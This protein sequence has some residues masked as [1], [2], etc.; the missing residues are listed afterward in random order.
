MHRVAAG[1]VVTEN[2]ICPQLSFITLP[3][4]IPAIQEIIDQGTCHAALVSGELRVGNLHGVILQVIAAFVCPGASE[5]IHASAI[6]H[7]AGNMLLQTIVCAQNPAEQHI[8]LW[9]LCHTG[10]H[11]RP[12]YLLL[13]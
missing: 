8:H 9:T 3:M 4:P 6:V 12:C 11:E 7:G 10:Q 1:K 5:P 13:V 2:T